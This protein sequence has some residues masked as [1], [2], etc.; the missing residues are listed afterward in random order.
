[1][2]LSHHKSVGGYSLGEMMVTIA[3]TGTLLA[4]SFTTLSALRKTYSAVD[5][6]FSTHLQ[7]IRIIDYLSRDVKRSLSVTTSADRSAVTCSIPNYVG[8]DG[9]RHSPG[10]TITANGTFIDYGRTVADAVLTEGSTT[11]SSASAAFTSADVGKVLAIPNYTKPGTTIHSVTS[12]TQAVMSR[13]ATHTGSGIRATVVAT[14]ATVAYTLETQEIKRIE[15]GVQTTIAK[16][17]DSLIP[18][19]IDVELANTEYT[20]SNVTFLPTF[21]F[22]PG[23][24]AGANGGQ[25]E[26]HRRKRAGTAVYATSYLRNRR[27]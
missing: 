12:A 2:R 22:N 18:D 23:N 7:Q 25:S 5:N 16:S 17:T 21:N 4:A 27:R 10:I 9:K 26:Y 3:I 13:K 15:N 11:I 14:P 6:Y 19:T 20:I 1:M 8:S 24:S